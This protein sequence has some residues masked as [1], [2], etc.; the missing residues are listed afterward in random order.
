[1]GMTSFDFLFNTSILRLNW[2]EF[3][4]LKCNVPKVFEEVTLLPRYAFL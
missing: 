2:F 3:H 4:I 1:M